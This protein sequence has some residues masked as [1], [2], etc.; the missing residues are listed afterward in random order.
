MKKY[1]RRK[2][3]LTRR[4]NRNQSKSRLKNVFSIIKLKKAKKRMDI[5]SILER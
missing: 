1:Q 4:F 2:R 3:Y 5:L